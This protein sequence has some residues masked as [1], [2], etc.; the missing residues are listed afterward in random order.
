[1]VRYRGAVVATWLAVLVLGLLSMSGL[2]NLLST[3]L[4]VPGTDSAQAN[5]ILLAHFGE[6]VEGS[7]TVVLAF[8]HATPH[9]VTAL[10]QRLARSAATVAGGR[11]IEQRAIGGVLYADVAT[12]L[13]FRDATVATALFRRTLEREGL[14][15][16]LVTGP[17]A[18]NY[19]LT[20]V[21]ASDL[22]VG[23]VVALLV[24]LLLLVAV[25]G[26]C[27]AVVVPFLVASATVAGAIGVAFLLAHHV[28]MVLYVPN[29]IALIG[30]GLAIDYS[31]LIVHRF[32][33][34]LAPTDVE[35]TNAIV[36]T[37]ASAGRSVVVS[38]L[39]VGIGLATLMLV[40]VPFV[41]SLGVAGLVVPAVALGAT[42]TLQPALLS[43]LGRGGVRPRGVPGVMGADDALGT[44][45]GRVAR[46]VQD[47]PVVVLVG[48][49]TLLLALTTGALWLQLTPG[50]IYAIPP[51]L[52]SARALT[53][54][55]DRI[56]PGV[57][58]PDQI[59]IDLGAAHR[60]N[61]PSLSAA[62]LHLAEAVLHDPE[63]FAAAIDVKAPFVDV[64][65]RYE[66]ILVIGRHEF[67]AVQS[68]Q[69]VRDLR[70][71]YVAPSALASSARIYV[72]GAPAQGVDFLGSVYGAFPWIVLL[73]LVLA[74]VVLVRAFRS[75]LLPLVAVVLNLL[76]VAA[77]YGL[78]AI[79]FRFGVGSSL[80]GTYRVS[81]IEG[82]VPIFLFA[83]L[84]GLSMDYEVFIVSRMRESWDQTH[85]S[86]AAI[87][88]GLTRTGG[89][90]S[91]AAVILVGA[92][93]GL[94]AG[95]VAGLQELGVG[96]AFGVVL[97]ATVV[98]GLVLPSVMTLLGRW[99]W[100][101]PAT[102]ARVLR[103][104]PTPG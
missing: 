30:F 15:R 49:T 16:A 3:S 89:V 28:L 6:N 46:R 31:L 94:I 38:S 48:A 36:A 85:D 55:N 1:M 59:V 100:W 75:V 33:E 92:L 42:L 95:H 66:Q 101:L 29:V 22:R 99:S 90:V 86:R 21:L 12:T 77:V 56:G 51:T 37:M 4:V 26:L 79:V 54:A 2:N 65:G 23:E 10:E 57:I 19:D 43:I 5:A 103:E 64:T 8:D 96:L 93:A 44:A 14:G 32:R 83:M 45:W 53:L 11:V 17:A 84:F 61:L 35:V 80:L 7:Y 52:Q 74:Y 18:L 102:V 27:W 78:L 13:D 40:P 88:E 24:A 73:A 70:S 60:A 41:R 81:Q 63:V 91:A 97:D 58:T 62:R 50:S 67:G 25:L 76:T 69:L 39:T 87:V 34:A 104:R 82:W 72:A 98:R 47:R 71:V 20:P 9:Q 68:Q